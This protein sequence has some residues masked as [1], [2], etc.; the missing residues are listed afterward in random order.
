MVT[1]I[2]VALLP[3][4]TATMAADCWIVVDLLR[5]TTTIAALFA[6]GLNELLVVDEI[7]RAREAAVRSGEALFGEVGG[8][9]PDG[10]DYGNSPN[11]ALGAPVAG[12]GAVLFTTNGTRALC[13]LANRGTVLTGALAN[14]A[15]VA[16]AA[17]PYGRVAIVC[18]G[19][20]GGRRFALE[21]FLAAGAIVRCLVESGAG[22]ELSDAAT[23][24]IAAAAAGTRDQVRASRH[25]RN[26]ASLGLGA[27]IEFA[28]REDTSAVA[29]AVVSSGEGW[30]LLADARRS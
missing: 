27:D 8:L 19:N 7:G 14:L 5:A 26:L 22:I 28:L 2:D 6:A 25:A 4:E 11:E 13:A 17:A 29:P 3:A 12:R 10:F 20:E 21:D 30:A 9:R 16:G 24:A 18:A 23:A 15:A 1:T